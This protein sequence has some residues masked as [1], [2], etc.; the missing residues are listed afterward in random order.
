MPAAPRTKL[1]HQV[2]VRSYETDPYGRLQPRILCQLLQEAA[3]L[4][5]DQ[6]GVAVDLLIES[7]VAWV[8]STL[9]L[10]MARWP[11]ADEV[12]TITTWPEA[13]DRLFTER[14]FEIV[15]ASDIMIG[16]AVTLWLVL[17]LER[18]RPVRLP[19]LVVD[20]LREH[21]LGDAPIRGAQLDPP[22]EP[23]RELAF[24]VRRSDLDLAGHVNNTSYVEWV[25]EAVDDVVWA[26]CDL[27]SL[28]IKFLSECHHGQTVLSRCRT[29]HRSGS[30]EA[31]HAILRQE[32]G[33]EA[34]RAKTEWRER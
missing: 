30:V 20:R 23:Q 33:V 14:R 10:E 4:H 2:A 29:T 18:R 22:T 8:L 6:L 11:G 7:G 16:H 1:R 32:D 12:I 25:V 9:H 3:T 13:A 26:S 15:D 21:V 5:A 28:E 19:P 31:Q 17:D 24:T 34:A 27:A